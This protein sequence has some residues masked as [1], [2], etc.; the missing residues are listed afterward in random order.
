MSKYREAFLVIRWER[1]NKRWEENK[2]GKGKR[3][4]ADIKGDNGY[5]IM[6]NME[7]KQRDLLY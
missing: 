1:R 3:C 5:F 2:G 4:K 7:I 6:R